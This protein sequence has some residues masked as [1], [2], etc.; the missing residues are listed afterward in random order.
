LDEN[1]QIIDKIKRK[2]NKTIVFDDEIVFVLDVNIDNERHNDTKNDVK[3]TNKF[4]NK[5][6]NK[7]VRK[8][9]IT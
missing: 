1:E 3:N 8:K 4:E 7:R 6:G 5:F 9:S 2:L